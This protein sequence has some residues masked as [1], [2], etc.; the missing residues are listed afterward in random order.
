M[1]A[2][3]GVFG[4]SGDQGRSE[5]RSLK[6]G[7]GYGHSKRNC[8]VDSFLTTKTMRLQAG[9][10]LWFSW[11]SRAATS[12]QAKIGNIETERGSMYSLRQVSA[13]EYRSTITP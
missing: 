4:K 3:I 13:T 5:L 6:A 10:V 2:K 12:R 8:S 7:Q 11:D 1:A 9:G